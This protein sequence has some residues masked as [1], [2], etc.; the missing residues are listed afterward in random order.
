[1]AR[2]AE[3]VEEIWLEVRP[4]LM[5]ARKMYAKLGFLEVDWDDLPKEIE[6]YVMVSPDILN[7]Q[8]KVKNR[9]Y[10]HRNEFK[11]MRLNLSVFPEL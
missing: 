8:A 9:V 1:M 10:Q 3:G 4:E 5:G 6:D 7:P 2:R 11:L